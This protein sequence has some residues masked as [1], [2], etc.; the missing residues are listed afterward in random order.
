MPDSIL[1]RLSGK[2]AGGK[3]R[4]NKNYV[5]ADVKIRNSGDLFRWDGKRRVSSCIAISR[6]LWFS[7]IADCIRN[8]QNKDAKQ[9]GRQLRVGD[10][11]YRILMHN[12]YEQFVGAVS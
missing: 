11:S 3:L 2:R 10:V 12:V 6:M 8:F 7:K 1:F 4:K 9:T 5:N